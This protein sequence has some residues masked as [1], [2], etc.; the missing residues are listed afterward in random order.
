[1]IDYWL[2]PEGAWSQPG[3]G[4]KAS[5]PDSAWNQI[6]WAFCCCR[7]NKDHLCPHSLL[8]YQ[9]HTCW[10]KAPSGDHLLPRGHLDTFS[11]S[12]LFGPGAADVSEP[13]WVLCRMITGRLCNRRKITGLINKY[14]CHINKHI[15]VM[16]C[17]VIWLTIIQ[18]CELQPGKNS[19]K[20]S[21]NQPDFTRATIF[22]YCIHQLDFIHNITMFVITYLHH[23]HKIY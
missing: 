12:I 10:K 21:N 15:S 5:A 11:G 16:S 20:W 17:V 13:E 4:R 9:L 19:K 3:P 2:A 23:F 22:F 8:L 7:C 14:Y 6:I 1:M 18:T